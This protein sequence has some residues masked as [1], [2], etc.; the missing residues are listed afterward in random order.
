MKSGM[1]ILLAFY[2]REAVLETL[3]FRIKVIHVDCSMWAKESAWELLNSAK[4]EVRRQKVDA[5]SE[6]KL[7]SHVWLF[8]TPWTVTYQAPLSME[9]SRQEYWSE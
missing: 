3:N 1:V 9:F 8:V 7:L 5:V 6:W 2:F 4:T